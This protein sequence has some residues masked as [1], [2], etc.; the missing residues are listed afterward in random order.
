MIPADVEGVCWPAPDPAGAEP[1][2]ALR[3]ARAG[4]RLNTLYVHRIPTTGEA[5]ATS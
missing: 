3:V 4:G 5:L 1:P 2:A